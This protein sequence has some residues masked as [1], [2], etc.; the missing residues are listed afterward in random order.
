MC[1]LL[2]QGII[3]SILEVLAITVFVYLVLPE[4]P[5]GIGILLLCGVFSFQTL[6]DI[7]MIMN[8][9]KQKKPCQRRMRSRGD[10]FSIRDSDISDQNLSD[11]VDPRKCSVMYFIAILLEN[12]IVKG[13][14]LLFQFIGI[15]GFSIAW[16]FKSQEHTYDLILQPVIGY[17]MVAFVLSVLWSNFFQT[18]ISKPKQEPENKPMVEEKEIIKARF[19]SSKYVLFH[20]IVVS[21]QQNPRLSV[22]EIL[23]IS[24][25]CMHI[26]I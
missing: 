8:Q 16:G 7:K 24:L 1:Y 23:S 15:V 19:K 9:K 12:I 14:V 2:A 3:G 20:E 17:P 10:Y 26:H 13:L 18:E 22:Y 5:S 4:I 21:L 11:P 6:V 25:A